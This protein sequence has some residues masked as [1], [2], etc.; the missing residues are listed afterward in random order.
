MTNIT[1]SV[2][3]AGSCVEGTLVYVPTDYAFD[4]R[5]TVGPNEYS[6]IQIN[7]LQL[8]IDYDGTVLYAYGYCPLLKYHETDL[9]PPALNR[10]ARLFASS[11]TEWIP[12]IAQTIGGPTSWPIWINRNCGWV[13]LGDPGYE[14]S[15]E[16]IEFAPDSIAV[17]NGTKLVAVWL[18]PKALP[19]EE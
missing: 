13:C 12:G 17:L 4:F 3:E 18:R 11:E 1:F 16:A 10:A 2:G 6:S 8:A 7:S 15:V 9:V 5:V 19:D 14:E